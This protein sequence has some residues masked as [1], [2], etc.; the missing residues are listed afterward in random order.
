VVAVD[1]VAY[2]GPDRRSQPRQRFSPMLVDVVS[3]I[4]IV[5]SLLV[6]VIAASTSTVRIQASYVFLR[7]ITDGLFLLTGVVLIFV[8]RL[9]GRAGPALSGAAFAVFGGVMLPVQ[10]CGPLLHDDQLAALLL[11]GGQLALGL[12][13]A[14]LLLRAVFLSPVD[15]AMRPGRLVSLAVA[16]AGTALVLLGALRLAFGVLDGAT[17][18]SW[19]LAALSLLWTLVAVCHRCASRDAERPVAA[20]TAVGIA[21]LA[22]S[23]AVLAVAVHG[24]MVAAVAAGAIEALAAGVVLVAALDVVSR[25]LRR[26]GTRTLRLVGE[27][28]DTVRVLADEQASREELLHD[29]R[30][31]LAAIRFT[32]GTLRSQAERL[33]RKLQRQLRDALASELQR[34]ENLLLAQRVDRREHFDLTAAVLPVIRLAQDAGARVTVQVPAAL[35][36][37]G[38]PR[39]TATAVHTVL[40]NAARYAVGSTVDVWAEQGEHDIRLCLGDRGPGVDPDEREAVFRRGFRGR[41]SDGSDGSGLGLFIA[42]R[43]MADQDGSLTVV[44]RDGGGA[45][46]VIT[47]PRRVTGQLG[48][49]RA[50]PVRADF[51]GGG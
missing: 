22:V 29:A 31:T 7:N 14:A 30:S 45:V 38:K 9:T 16:A 51:V 6:V 26:D 47:L 21:L 49:V 5:G 24:R 23:D 33:D 43:L 37:T 28:G 27:L 50:D 15:T 34:L 42:R 17:G 40:T 39:D 2:R 25:V 12:P 48:A 32:D 1:A 44:P 20:G 18:W 46:F 36:A 10:A 4:L 41:A 8:W 3:W 13:A 19:C 11:P 35:W